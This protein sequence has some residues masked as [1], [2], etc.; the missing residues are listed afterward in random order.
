MDDTELPR[1]QIVYQKHRR[2]VFLQITLP[3]LVGIGLFIVAFILVIMSGR[4]GAS[5]EADVALIWLLILPIFMTLIGCVIVG[6][7]VY[8]IWKLIEVLPGNMYKLQNALVMVRNKV[9]SFS[10]YSTAPFIKAQ[11]VSASLSAFWRS[12]FTK[13]TR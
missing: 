10:S 7:L 5:Q 2:E 9:S 8:G 3:V 6:A 1:D 13:G 4:Q 12:L 11:S